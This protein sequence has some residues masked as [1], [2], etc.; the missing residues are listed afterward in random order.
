MDR[1]QKVTFS[2]YVVQYLL[3]MVYQPTWHRQQQTLN[4]KHLP[5]VLA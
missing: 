4:Q 1:R 5:Q 3:D 2:L